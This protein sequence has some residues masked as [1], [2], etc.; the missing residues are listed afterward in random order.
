MTVLVRA[1]SNLSKTRQASSY[2]KIYV[3]K[4][5]DGCWMKE[6]LVP[7]VKETRFLETGSK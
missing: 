5:I 6:E 3:K 1:S 7:V 4:P 2:G